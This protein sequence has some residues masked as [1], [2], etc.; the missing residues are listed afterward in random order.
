MTQYSNLFHLFR[1]FPT[2]SPD[3]DFTIFCL[4]SE[5][6]KWKN[7]H[8]GIFP[9]TWY[10]QIDGGSENANQYLIA[11]ME[12]LVI[13]RLVKKIVLTRYSK[14]KYPYYI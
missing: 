11:A 4:L 13:K 7:R 5:L 9:E 12:F 2:V 10:I 14:Y 1:S 8:N 6:E 3:S